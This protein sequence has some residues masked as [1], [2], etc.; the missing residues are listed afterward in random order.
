MMKLN[1]I[2]I[3]NIKHELNHGLVLEKVHQGI[4]FN[5]KAWLKPYIDMNTK[6]RQKAQNNFEKTFFKL[7]NNGAF[8]NTMENVKKHKNLKLVITER[9]K[10]YL[11]LESNYHT[12]K[13]FTEH[14]LPIE[15]KY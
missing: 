3:R 15:L 4:K 8:G 12:T 11:A 6:L 5:H 14:V 2:H 1:V 9:R 10:N 7:M 13:F